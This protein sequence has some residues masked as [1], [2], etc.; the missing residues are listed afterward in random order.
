MEI[1]YDVKE[2]ES[3]GGGFIASCPMMKPVRIYARTR[4]EIP[5][6]MKGAVTFYMKFHPELE[7]RMQA[8]TIRV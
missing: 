6:K 8:Q 1:M 5:S 2:D 7:E 4:E 3:G